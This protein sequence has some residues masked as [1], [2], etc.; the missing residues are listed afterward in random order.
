L[1]FVTPRTTE[2]DDEW[3]LKVAEIYG[4]EKLDL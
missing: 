4:R 2:I 1:A 3:D